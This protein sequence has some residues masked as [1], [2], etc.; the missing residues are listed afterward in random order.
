MRI[1]TYDIEIRRAIL[2]GESAEEFE[3]QYPGIEYC[4][5]FNDFNQMGIGCVCALVLDG[6]LPLIYDQYNLQ[7]FQ[8]VLDEADLIVSYNGDSFDS[9]VLAANGVIVPAHKSLD[10]LAE[11]RKATGTRFSLDAMAEKNLKI[12][13][14]DSGKLAP[15]LWQQGHRARV[16]NYCLNDCLMTQELYRL[17]N[18]QGYLLT[19]KGQR[20]SLNL[21]QKDRLLF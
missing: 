10:L 2:N 18:A 11:I 12:R 7:E 20:V 1:V 6:P 5:T 3:E 14:T 15:I 16:I 21:E 8:Q 13:K 9:R 17:A 19:P 4:P